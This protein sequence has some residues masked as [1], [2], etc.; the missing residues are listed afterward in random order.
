MFII[1]IISVV[2]ARPYERFVIIKYYGPRKDIFPVFFEYDHFINLLN[3][4]F[5]MLLKILVSTI[6]QDI[7]GM[8][9]KLHTM[10][11]SLDQDCIP[12]SIVKPTLL[13]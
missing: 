5:Q 10:L 2:E 1:K 4:I 9:G 7:S 3:D 6:F 11:V 12:F 8:F 13:L